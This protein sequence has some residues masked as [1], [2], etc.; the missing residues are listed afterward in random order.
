M[1]PFAFLSTV[2]YPICFTVF[3][4]FPESFKILIHEFDASEA[5]KIDFGRNLTG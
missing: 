5:C 1:L 3:S 4:R 2:K